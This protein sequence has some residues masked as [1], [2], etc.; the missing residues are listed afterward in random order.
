MTDLKGKTF[1][2]THTDHIV[3]RDCAR[4]CLRAGARVLAHYDP[5]NADGESLAADLGIRPRDTIAADLH[6]PEHPTGLWNAAL[7]RAH[8]IDGL[9]NVSSIYKP[10]FMNGG[11]LAWL[12][13]WRRAIQVNL[14]APVDLCRAAEPHF[15]ANGG[16]VIVA[17][18]CSS[19]EETGGTL[20][21]ACVAARGGLISVCRTLSRAYAHENI[22]IYVLAPDEADPSLAPE[23]R[24]GVHDWVRTVPYPSIKGNEAVGEL[25][26]MMC[27]EAAP[28]YARL[29]GDGNP[30]GPLSVASSS[31]SGPAAGAESHS[32]GRRASA[33]RKP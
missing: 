6:I 28:A 19:R 21:S 2:V 20:D 30:V 33:A 1:L 31:G 18:S 29:W 13:S 17:V 27:E 24:S 14:T 8:R 3:G 32:S 26:A 22:A 4:A 7:D 11:D 10:S 16:G 15:R 25:V 23:E 9:V 12:G 5:L